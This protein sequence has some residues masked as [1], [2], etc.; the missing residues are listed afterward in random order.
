MGRVMALTPDADAGADGDRHELTE[1]MAATG[2]VFLTP[3]PSP[4]SRTVRTLSWTWLASPWTA[5]RTATSS[6]VVTV[7]APR[8]LAVV[9]QNRAFLKC[10]CSLLVA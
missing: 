10:S 5:M 6:R 9:V 4:S 8:L 7:V 1:A 2:R 3:G